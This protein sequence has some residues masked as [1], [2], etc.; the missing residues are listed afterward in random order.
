M[1]MGVASCKKVHNFLNK[2]NKYTTQL[3]FK[4]N[5]PV[6]GIYLQNEIIEFGNSVLPRVLTLFL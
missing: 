2:I 1:A 6:T 3:Y 5:N 4:C